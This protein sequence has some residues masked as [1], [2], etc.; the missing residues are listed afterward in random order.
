MQS[1]SLYGN[2]VFLNEDNR[3][4]IINTINGAVYERI[5]ELFY[6]LWVTTWNHRNATPT[7]SI[8]TL[9]LAGM[10]EAEYEEYPYGNDNSKIYIPALLED[11]HW[12]FYRAFDG[13]QVRGIPKEGSPIY[14]GEFRITGDQLILDEYCW[15]GDSKEHL[16]S[17]EYSE[18]KQVCSPED[19]KYGK[20]AVKSRTSSTEDNLGVIR[21]IHGLN[22]EYCAFGEIH[23]IPIPESWTPYPEREH[24]VW[25]HRKVGRLTVLVQETKSGPQ[26]R[27]VLCQLDSEIELTPLEDKVLYRDGITL[28]CSEGW[29]NLSGEWDT[30]TG[31]WIDARNLE[32]AKKYPYRA[33]QWTKQLNCRGQEAIA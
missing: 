9:N 33:S 26:F 17:T 29:F 14:G 11:K 13:R 20:Y 18:A 30:M 7:K 1:Q 15:T 23:V 24:S 4:L 21:G 22:P 16:S 10:S 2:R 27:G 12:S 25:E 32:K 8:D 19:E 6:P 5:G 31:E 28:V 3:V